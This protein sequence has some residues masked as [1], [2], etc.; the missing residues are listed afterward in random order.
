MEPSTADVLSWCAR[1]LNQSGQVEA[2]FRVA[3]QAIAMDPQ[4]A[5]RRLALAYDALAFGRYDRAAREARM[6]SELEPDLML[7]RAI[8]AR[9]HLLAGR[10][11]RCAAMELGPHAAIRAMCLHELGRRA[12]ASAIV[13]SLVAG[14]AAGGLQDSVFTDVIRAEDLATYY[15]WVGDPTR[16]LSW[17]VRAYELSPSGVEPRVLES[18]LFDRVKQDPGFSRQVARLR[19]GIWDRVRRESDTPP[20]RN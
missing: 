17:V 12:E 8:E 16:S 14:L 9:A 1:V 2:A 20:S 7:S 19:E 13:D 10:A 11:E 15:A 18:A 4:N 5:G 6:A 3:E